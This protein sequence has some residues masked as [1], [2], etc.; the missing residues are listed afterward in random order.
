MIFTDA[1][2]RAR[3]RVLA[4]LIGPDNGQVGSALPGCWEA[5]LSHPGERLRAAQLPAG[6][7]RSEQC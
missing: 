6:G 5:F 4:I 1:A 3:L 2:A 7:P